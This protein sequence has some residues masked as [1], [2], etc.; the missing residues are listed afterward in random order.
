MKMGLGILQTGIGYYK[1]QLQR[2]KL[3]T[4]CVSAALGVHVMGMLA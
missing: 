3:L 4:I 1:L 2:W